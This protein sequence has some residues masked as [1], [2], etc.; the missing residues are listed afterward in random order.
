MVINNKLNILDFSTGIKAAD[1]NF[2]FNIVKGWIERERLRTAGYGLVEGFD[3]SYDG[4]FN[5]DIKNGVLINEDGEEILVDSHTIA[6]GELVYETITEDVIVNEEGQIK[7]RYMPYSPS[8]R[9]LIIYNPPQNRNKPDS[10][11]L[12]ITE[13]DSLMK[14]VPFSVVSNILTVSADAWAGKT[15]HIT[16]CYCNDSIDAILLD[17]TGL[18]RREQ[19]L[20]ST[21]PSKT[22]IDL[23]KD[24]IIG[25]AHWIIGEKITVEFIIDD[26]TYRKVYVNPENI[27]YL[28]GKPYKEAKWIYFVEP[29][30]PQSDDVWYDRKSN[31]LCIWSETNGS[32]G[33]VIMNDFTNIPI[34]TAKIWTK[35]ICPEDLQTFLFKDDETNLRF[36]PG[37][38]ALE[39]VIDQQIVM[40]DQFIEIIQKGSKPYLSS[41]IGFKLNAPLDRATD[42]QV[43]VNHVV[44]N[45]ALQ[46]VFQRAAIFVA[47]NF[48]AYTSSNVSKIFET[49]LEY[50]IGASQLEVFVDGSRL[51]KD[52]DF[53]EMANATKLA[54][55]A[56]KD[57]MTKFFA[58]NIALSPGQKVAYK[59]SRY[60]WSYD[61]LNAMME[62]IEAK[63]DSALIQ[64]SKLQSQLINIVNNTDNEFQG[65]KQEIA[66]INNTLNTLCD[67]RKKS[68]KIAE[69]D[70]D[71][72]I[73]GKLFKN[74]E[75]HVFNAANID[76]KIIDLKTTD[77]IEV[78]Y[79]SNNMSKQLTRD[80]EYSV[81]Y[82]GNSAQ[83]VLVAELMA[84]EATVLVNVI[85]FGI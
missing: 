73:T 7:L 1:I 74:T 36:M 77:F 35:K 69:A 64:T 70:L 44:K 22:D 12:K 37:T 3:L 71:T 24:Y 47:E 30:N 57:S 6:C 29:E 51:N 34:R 76:N 45:G 78:N 27:L 15:A 82:N 8:N 67:Y 52:I 38:N 16:Y 80:S 28:N 10:N 50:A 59:I 58:V 5:I 48:Q 54:T 11:E 62:D 17:K 81:V 20:L 2:D 49:D 79:I 43:I 61:Q 84:S 14:M 56:D 65:I 19:G 72:K 40:S 33:W 60:V 23:S 63:A 26:R 46:N 75:G 66:A 21:S 85:R 25:F 55:F 53:I 42:V 83:I 68:D 13:R 18:Y 32:Y 9:G 31:A 4:A 39:I 41:G